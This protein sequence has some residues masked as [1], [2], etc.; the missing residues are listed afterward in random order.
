[1]NSGKSDDD[2]VVDVDDDMQARNKE[3]KEKVRALM[4]GY[5]LL[6]QQWIQ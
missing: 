6:S 5:A 1:M 3:I 4:S 2:D